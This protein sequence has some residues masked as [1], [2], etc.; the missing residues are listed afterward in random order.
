MKKTP[1][2]STWALFWNVVFIPEPTPRC[3]GGRLFI[4]PARL[5]AA[6]APMESPFSSRMSPKAQYEKL[7]GSSSSSRKD[8]AAAIIP[9]EANGRE[10]KWSESIPETGPAS[11]N[12]AVSGSM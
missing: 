7:T 1:I 2:D 4:T 10:P 9:P 5:G 12:P 8:P 6:K 3:C 11:R